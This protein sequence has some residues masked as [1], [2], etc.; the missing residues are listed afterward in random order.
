MNKKLDSYDV[1]ILKSFMKRKE[2]KF[3]SDLN[4]VYDMDYLYGLIPRVLKAEKKLNVK[5]EDISPSTKDKIQRYIKD[6]GDLEDKIY[7]YNMKMVQLII[8]KYYTDGG[9]KNE[10]VS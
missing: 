6:F 4:L 9:I 3:V 5:I 1:L 10:L 2:A 7:Y 8:L